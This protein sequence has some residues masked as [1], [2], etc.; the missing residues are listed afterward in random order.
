MASWS[1]D[2]GLIDISVPRRHGIVSVYIVHSVKGNGEFHQHALAV[3][4]WYKTD[5]D[6]GH[7]AKPAQ[8]WKR[9][10]YEPC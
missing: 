5:C 2:D 3:V 8:V 9:H 7:F 6:Q 10:D 1:G 4:W